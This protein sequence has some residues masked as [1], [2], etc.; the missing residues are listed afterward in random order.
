MTTKKATKSINLKKAWTDLLAGKKLKNERIFLQD[1]KFAYLFAKYFRKNRYDEQDEF[2]FYKD[3]KC[4]YLYCVFL[5]K[6]IPE[7]LHNFMIAK[8]LE[9]LNEE[10]SR[11]VKEYLDWVSKIKKRS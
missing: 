4:A 5:E 7:H 1:P 6:K 3:I 9:N 11:W 8:N 2:I 10:D